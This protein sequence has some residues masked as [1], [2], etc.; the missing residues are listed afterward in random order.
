MDTYRETKTIGEKVSSSFKKFMKV[1]FALSCV[2]VALLVIKVGFD[3]E[4]MPEPFEGE[5]SNVV[6]NPIEGGVNWIT[7]KGESLGG[8]IRDKTTTDADSK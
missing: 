8:W 2:A 6:D 3:V 4:N 1:S 7:D 5:Q